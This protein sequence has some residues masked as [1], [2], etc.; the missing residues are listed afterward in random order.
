MSN[1]W[2]MFFIFSHEMGVEWNWEKKTENN[3]K[4]LTVTIN[5]RR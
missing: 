5:E 3:I 2:S 1:F 4:K